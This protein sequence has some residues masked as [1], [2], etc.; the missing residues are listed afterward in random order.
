MLFLTEQDVKRALEGQSTYR[1]AV[2]V[3]ERVLKQQSEGST[4]H[5][6][7]YTMEHPRH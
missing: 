1:E 2:E 4:F 6:K 3:I 7:R 5:L